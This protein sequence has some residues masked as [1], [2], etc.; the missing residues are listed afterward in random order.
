MDRR[1]PSQA[2]A[3]ELLREAEAR[4]ATLDTRL[5]ALGRRAHPT[6]TEQREMTELK[7]Q[8][9]AAKDEIVRLRRLA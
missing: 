8:K 7:K 1:L 9:L 3:E 5:K 4:H 2:T 6:P